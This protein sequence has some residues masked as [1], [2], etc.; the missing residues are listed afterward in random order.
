MDSISMRE[1]MHRRHTVR[2]YTDKAIP[3]ET[4]E[5][6]CGRIDDNNKK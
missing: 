1:A 3:V 5:Q 2:R 4:M 6:L